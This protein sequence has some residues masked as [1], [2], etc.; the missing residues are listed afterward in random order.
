MLN[1]SQKLWT[2][3]YCFSLGVIFLFFTP[4]SHKFYGDLEGSGYIGEH[5]VEY[6]GNFFKIQEALV[7]PKLLIE[8]GSLTII[9][10]LILFVLKTKK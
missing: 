6:F 7:Y 8:I 10:V 9:Y 5:R 3:I 1:K 4:Y 2:L